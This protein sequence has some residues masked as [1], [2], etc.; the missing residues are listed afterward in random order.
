MDFWLGSL[1]LL[2]LLFRRIIVYSVVH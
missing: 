1:L 2:L